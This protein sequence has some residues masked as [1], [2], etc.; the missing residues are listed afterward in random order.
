MNKRF[1]TGMALSVVAALCALSLL[2]CTASEAF[3]AAEER[4]IS[5]NQT[6][7]ER[8]SAIDD[9]E[10]EEAIVDTS[11]E[12]DDVADAQTEESLEV[13]AENV[14]VSEVDVEDITASEPTIND[15]A[16]ETAVENAPE[17]V[18]AMLAL[19]SCDAFSSTDYPASIDLTSQQPFARLS[20]DDVSA[21]YLQHPLVGS[22]QLSADEVAT[23]ITTLQ[24]LEISEKKA[25]PNLWVKY[26]NAYRFY[27]VGSNGELWLF[28]ARCSMYAD[29]ALTMAVMFGDEIAIGFD[30]KAME[31]VGAVYGMVEAQLNA[32]MSSKMTP[33]ANLSTSEI[34]KA[35]YRSNFDF[36]PMTEEQTEGLV[37]LLRTVSIDSGQGTGELPELAGADKKADATDMQ[38]RLTFTNGATLTVGSRSGIVIGGIRYAGDWRPI[39]SYYLSMF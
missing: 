37:E 4:S 33:F 25:N 12:Y 38:F 21:V 7:S 20:T 16:S 18:S 29:D 17:S 6:S 28:D 39:Y 24:G 23:L 36:Y 34:A 15:S 14:E 35:E 31:A 3:D 22:V 11:E 2:G 10:A 1:R 32:S 19:Q 8:A 9:S 26:D 27:V 30:R 5:V 13:V